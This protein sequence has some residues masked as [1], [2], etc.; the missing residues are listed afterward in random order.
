MT[1]GYARWIETLF[2]PTAL[3]TVIPRLALFAGLVAL[4]ALAVGALGGVGSRRIRRRSRQGIGGRAR[5]GSDLSNDRGE[6]VRGRVVE[7]DSRRGADSDRRPRSELAK[8][9]LELLVENLGQP[10]FREL[11]VTVHDVDARRD[12]VFAL[13]QPRF[14]QRFFARVS[15]A[16]GV[17][18]AEASLAGRA[19]ADQI[20]AGSRQLEAFDLAGAA[21]GHVLDAMEGALALPLAVDPHLLTFAPEG[22]GAVKRIGCAIVRGACCGCSRKW[23]RRARSR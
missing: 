18:Q 19:T 11:L 17:R 9:Y 14:R 10:G 23:A 6:P 13:L 16:A 3:P 1:S 20:D 4:G 7:P 5:A 8:K 15:V 2:S 21:R 12:L 22:P